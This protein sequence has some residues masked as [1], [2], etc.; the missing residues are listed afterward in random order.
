MPNDR[1]AV[2]RRILE[3]LAA[4]ARISNAALAEQVGIAPS[5]CLARVRAL[6]ED[7]VIQGFHAE[8]DLAASAGRCRR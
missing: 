6:R 2:D 5:T 7:G 8:I 3:A 1:D 4:D